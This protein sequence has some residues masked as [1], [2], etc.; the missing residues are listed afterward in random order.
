MCVC[1]VYTYIRF[2]GNTGGAGGRRGESDVNVLLM[3]EIL[4]RIKL[5]KEG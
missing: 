2:G 3:Y 1:V 5:F 4:S